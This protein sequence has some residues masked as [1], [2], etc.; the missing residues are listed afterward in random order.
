MGGQLQFR[1]VDSTAPDCDA[2][3]IGE[4]CCKHL[5]AGTASKRS[6]SRD[7]HSEGGEFVGA[8]D[9]EGALDFVDEVKLLPNSGAGL[10][11]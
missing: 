9:K 2:G 5:T 10:A 4:W 11:A 3:K 8:I 1:A 7:R 6:R